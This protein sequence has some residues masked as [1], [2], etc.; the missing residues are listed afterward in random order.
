MKNMNKIKETFF[1]RHYNL[2]EDRSNDSIP[3]CPKCNIRCTMSAKAKNY[4]TCFQCIKCN[5]TMT[6][7]IRYIRKSIKKDENKRRIEFPPISLKISF[8]HD[9]DETYYKIDLNYYFIQL[10]KKIEPCRLKITMS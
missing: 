10:I 4:R 1:L 3:I 2:H 5:M 9:K 7:M 6:D 8:K